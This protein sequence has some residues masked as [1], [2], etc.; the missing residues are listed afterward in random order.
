MP[1]HLL[2]NEHEEAV[3]A[4][5]F[6]TRAVQALGSNGYLWRW[7]IVGMHNALQGLMVLALR[8]GNG[9]A[10]LP[11]ATAEEWL[12]AHREGTKRP[13]EQLDSFLNLY[14]KIKSGKMQF[15]V[16]SRRF[17]PSGS[18]G[19]SMKLLNRLRNDFVHFLPN[20]WSLDLTGLPG[21]CLDCL[22]VGEF[23][24]NDSGNI[25]WRKSS[26]RVRSRVAIRDARVALAAA[27][28]RFR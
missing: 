15:F 21:M 19:R 24:I 8:G 25:S 22:D 10:V 27:A 28:K 17:V 11:D 20:S 12:K 23:L 6:T 7:V 5:E 1:S 3:L 16:H 4:L 18:Q 9:L 2:T 14:R 13:I 26:H